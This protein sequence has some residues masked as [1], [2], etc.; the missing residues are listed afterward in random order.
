[1]KRILTVFVLFVY[2]LGNGLVQAQTISEEAKSLI[3]E[4]LNGEIQNNKLSIGKVKILQIKQEKKVLKIYANDNLAYIPFRETNVEAIYRD[5]KEILGKELRNKK[6][7]LYAMN[8]LVEDF[9]PVAMRKNQSSKILPFA[10]KSERPLVTCTSSLFSPKSGLVGRHI[11]MWQSH[12]WYFE[13]KLNRWE[14]QRARCLQTV[15]D[16]YTQSYVLPFLVPMLEN[17]GANVLLPRERDTNREELIVDNDTQ[18]GGHYIEQNG[19]EA[20]KT[21]NGTGFARVREVYDSE[22]PFEEGTFRQVS[23]IVKGKKSVAKWELDIPR[24]G[25]YAVYV[26]YKTLKNSVNDARY[27]VCHLGGTTTFQVNQQM[28]GGTW[29]YLG[30][31]TF[32]K[33]G[34]SSVT[35]SNVSAK[36][37]MVVTADAVKVGGGMGNIARK[38][39]DA[40]SGE[41][42]GYPR[43]T[44]GA[45]YWLQWAGAPDSIY[46]LSKGEDDYKDDYR[47]R[48]RWVNWLAGGSAVIPKEK[49]LNIPVDMS[50]AFHSDA[51]T[52]LNDSLIGT[53]AIYMSKSDGSEKFANGSSRYLSHDLSDLV[54]TQIVEDVRALYEPE[55]PRRGMWNSSYYEAR[56]PQVPA[57]LLELLSHQNF[58]DMRYGLDPRFRFTVSRAIY[59]GILRFLSS[60]HRAPYVVQ[61]LPVDHLAANVNQQEVTLTWQPVVDELEATAMPDKY[62]VYTRIDNGGWDN[63]RIVVKPSYKMTMQPGKIYSWKVVAANE[64]G[65]SFPSEILS[66]AIAPGY[67]GKPALVVNGFDRISAP[68]DFVAPGEAGR[69]LAGFLDDYDYGVPYIKDISYIGQMKEF[70]RDIPWMNDDSSGFG[71]SF[72]DQEDKVI[73]G[74]TFDYPYTHGLALLQNGISFTSCS[75]EIVEEGK[76]SLD[77]YALVDLILG[78]QCQT[79]MGR[80]GVTPLAFKTFTTGMQQALTTYLQQQNGRLFVS[81]TYV[82]TDLWDNPLAEKQEADIKFAKDVLKYIWRVHQAAKHS[83]LRSTTSKHRYDYV[84]TFNE[85]VYKVDS[86]DALEPSLPTAKT[87]LRYTENNISAAVSYQGDDYAT[88]VMGVPF[89]TIRTEVERKE[90]MKEILKILMR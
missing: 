59:K 35:L 24:K 13:P 51:G 88:Y 76:I 58:A 83:G 7:Q 31:F 42:S 36:Q 79:K 78:K 11:A 41:V 50:F 86:P 56:V 23:S 45:R 54:Q 14:W 69:H 89:E 6:V 10:P 25:E 65:I 77:S 30:T 72:A 70:R 87:A 5:V 63:G 27:E 57:M 52:T 38:G 66:A 21:G 18:S 44:E 3:E 80:G 62:I 53:L 49:G 34:E 48:P 75:N 71:D 32:D 26:S 2:V 16:L 17:A 1:M 84:D 81:G 74:N 73:A 29:I 20:W 39:K 15:E 90:L 82:A 4:R 85:D 33:T 22:N 61:P 68:A 9:I 67:T 43:F 28:G 37:G 12:G 46:T 40:E 60:Q 19:K 55:W 47:S 64:G 8:R